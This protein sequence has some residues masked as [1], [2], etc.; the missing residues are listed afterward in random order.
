MNKAKGQYDLL[1]NTPVFPLLIRLSIPTIIGM[2]IGNVYN[3]V[4]T[5]FVGRLGNSASGAVG[6]VFGFMSILQ[7]TG[8][9]FGQGCGSILSRREGMQD[10]EG[11]SRAASIGFFSALTFALLIEGICFFKID[12]LITVL[13]STPTIAP[14]AKSYITWILL[15]APFMVPSYTMNNIL[16]YEGKAAIGTIGMM[17]GA[18][19]NIVLDPILM[20]GFKMGIAG[21]GIAT[22]ASQVVGFLILL[23][24]FLTGRTQAKLSIGRVLK[25]HLFTEFTDI[26]GTG[27][28]SLLR[29]ALNSISTV[30]MNNCAAVYGD[31]AVAAMSIVTRIGFFVFSMALGIGQGYQPV[32]AFNYGAGKY[33]RLKKAYGVAL[34]LSE[35]V[36]I[37]TTVLVMIF[38]GQMIQVF[39]D[40]PVVIEIG[41]RALRLLIGGQVFLPFCMINEMS[42][43][44][45]GHK[46][47]ASLLSSS[48]SGILF[49]PALII[50]SRVRGLKGIQEAQP[51]AMLLSLIPAAFVAA[52]FFRELGKKEQKEE[53]TKDDPK[54]RSAVG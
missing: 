9:L 17:S 34:K 5:A 41:T 11:A 53:V 18:I 42:M 48:R 28:P 40:D 46:L 32:C 6:I 21:A 1:V 45:T 15:A 44:S 26:V 30:L 39:R 13:G 38:S 31:E 23:S 43:Q 7:A 3:L 16:R 8:F 20:F 51:L 37:A 2:L 22:A 29:Q 27:L 24:M 33:D 54:D 36:M 19:L 4:D 52:S 10:Y 12:D 14:Y 35:A 25:A 50:L 49:V 47:E